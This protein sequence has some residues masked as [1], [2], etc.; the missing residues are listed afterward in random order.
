MSVSY[1]TAWR[2][3]ALVPKATRIKRV[4]IF[5]PIAAFKKILG[6]SLF[7][8]LFSRKRKRHEYFQTATA[9]ATFPS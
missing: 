1:Y 6:S 5:A 8:T 9:E 2:C 7:L 3:L 4:G